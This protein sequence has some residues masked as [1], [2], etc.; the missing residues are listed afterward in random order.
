MTIT[1][2][3][4]LPKE[5]IEQ[6][7]RD[8]ESHA[9]DDRKRR[10]S[11]E[12]RNRADSLV[13]Q[14]DKTLTD[15][16]DKL[17]AALK[18]EIEQAVGDLREALKGDD[19]QAVTTRMQALNALSQRLAEAIYHAAQPTGTTESEPEDAGIVDAEIVDEGDDQAAAS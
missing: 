19:D 11:V 12:L 8:A 7:I 10:E 6:M 1:G 16:G 5:D 17:D 13:Y 15:S 14:T 2:G 4:A 3:S 9:E 18:A